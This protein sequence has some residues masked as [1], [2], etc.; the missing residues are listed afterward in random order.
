MKL[1]IHKIFPVEGKTDSEL[2]FCWFLGKVFSKYGWKEAYTL[3][4]FDAKIILRGSV[5]ADLRLQDVQSLQGLMDIALF[6]DRRIGINMSTATVKKLEKHFKYNGRIAVGT[7]EVEVHQHRVVMTYGYLL[8]RLAAMEDWM[9]ETQSVIG[10]DPEELI[11]DSS[12][13][14]G[15][16]NTAFELQQMLNEIE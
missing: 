12:G 6:S 7:Q 11:E 3:D 15:R 4:A 14:T 16:L 9:Y 13:R 2:L 1:K 8:G 10:L 5:N